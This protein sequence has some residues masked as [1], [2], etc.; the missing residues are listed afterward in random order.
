MEETPSTNGSISSDFIEL[1]IS[2]LMTSPDATTITDTVITD[3]NILSP[4]IHS[5]LPDGP[6]TETTDD[7]PTD[8]AP[9][10][11]A[12]V[13]DSPTDTPTDDTPVDDKPVDD[14]PTDDA[15]TD[16]TTTDTPADDDTPTD[17]T[18]SDTPVDDAP[19][20]D[21]PADD[22]PPEAPFKA[23][24]EL[25][26]STGSIESIPDDF[27]NT[28]SGLHQLY[29]AEVEARVQAYINNLPET[30]KYLINTYKEGTPLDTL[31][32]HESI[33]Q[34][35]SNI[36]SENLEDNE[37]LQKQVLRS[38]HKRIGTSETHIA[39]EI[40]EA[41]EAETLSK[42]ATRH[43]KDLIS[44]EKADRDDLVATSAQEKQLKEE[45]Y[46]KQVSNLH[47]TLKEIDEIIPGVKLTE[48]DKR[49]IF[50]GITIFDRNHKNAYMRFRDSNPSF[51]ISSVYIALVKGG[52]MGVGDK[53]AVTKAAR[54]LKSE[55]GKSTKEKETPA[56]DT[57]IIKNFIAGQKF[58]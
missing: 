47:N 38:Y 30:A 54:K 31:L 40:N 46:D 42:K 16:D 43:L 23:I 49:T 6:L 36:T 2:P 27:D 32:Q 20:D 12:P 35:Y 37:E 41:V 15:P 5:G 56:I 44:Y 17:D 58:E 57:K 25:L 52:K 7:T 29:E 34:N 24:A 8:D 13:D 28:E 51:D 33:I 1:D 53:A 3:E 4:G 18:P 45:K 14:T 22:T 48:G 39:D 19:V 9:S 50:N 11:D 21:A 26:H 55:L 10:D